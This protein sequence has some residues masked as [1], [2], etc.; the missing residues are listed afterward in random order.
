MSLPRRRF[1][2]AHRV[3]HCAALVVLL[4][5]GGCATTRHGRTTLAEMQ[6]FAGASI[7]SF[8]F[9]RLHDWQAVDDQH[10]V[11]WTD[12][13]TAYLITTAGPCFELDFAW[14]LGVSATLD[15]VS[16]FEALFPGDHARCP[17]ADIQPLDVKRL[18]AARKAA[19]AAATGKDS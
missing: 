4:A 18:N 2:T 7:D 9:Y 15:R 11:I 14:R 13:W 3:A 6:P 17:V 5:F 16:R 12:P 10:V 8:H 1:V 19:R